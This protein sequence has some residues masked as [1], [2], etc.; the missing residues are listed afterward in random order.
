M[1]TCSSC[2]IIY[3]RRNFMKKTKIVFLALFIGVILS[4][5]PEEKDYYG[6]LTIQNAPAGYSFFAMIYP[7]STLPNN[8]PEYQSMTTSA[9]ATGDGSSPIKT[10]WGGNGTQSGRFLL[11]LRS[12]STTKLSVVNFKNGDAAVDWNTMTNEPTAY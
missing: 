9:I 7:S 1:T 3:F 8:Y 12:G 6:E 5:C 2:G 10:I 11:K 4:G